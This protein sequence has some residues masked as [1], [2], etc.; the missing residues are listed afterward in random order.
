MEQ[1]ADCKFKIKIIHLVI[2]IDRR[3]VKRCAQDLH[4]MSRCSARPMK[5]T[6]Q[7]N[8]IK[9]ALSPKWLHADR[10]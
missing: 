3:A 2:L 4:L 5:E 8:G 7:T 6:V 10:V 9:A 1:P